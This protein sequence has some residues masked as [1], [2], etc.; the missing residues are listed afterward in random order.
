MIQKMEMRDFLPEEIGTYIKGS[1]RR[2]KIAT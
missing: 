2:K 1:N